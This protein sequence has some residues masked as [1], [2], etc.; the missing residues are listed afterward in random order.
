M[1]GTLLRLSRGKLATKGNAPGRSVVMQGEG[2]GGSAMTAE[3]YQAPGILAVPGDGTRGVWLPVGGSTRYGVVIALHNYALSIQ[4]NAGETAIYSTDAAGQTVKALLT[5]K[6]DGSAEMTATK[7]KMTGD[8]EVTG[9][10]TASGNIEAA[11]AVKAT[12]TT[13]PVSLGT[14]QHPTAT[15]GPPSP[16]VPGT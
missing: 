12:A 8:I 6:A 16:P 14:H 2:P 9:K 10:I 13:V 15:P 4:V 5:L 3:V 1:I 7:L 11:G